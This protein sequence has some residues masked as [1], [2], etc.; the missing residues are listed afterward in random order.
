MK[1]KVFFVEW[2]DSWTLPY[3]TIVRANDAAQAWAKV[4]RRHPFTTRRLI[5]ITEYV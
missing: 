1:K 4:R 2:K 3:S 5:S